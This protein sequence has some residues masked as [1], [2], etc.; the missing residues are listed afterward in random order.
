M[1]SHYKDSTFVYLLYAFHHFGGFLFIAFYLICE[2]TCCGIFCISYFCLIQD[3]VSLQNNLQVTTSY[4]SPRLSPTS[5][6]TTGNHS[7]SFRDG[8]RS[9]RLVSLFFMALYTSI[10]ATNQVSISSYLCN[11]LIEKVLSI[12]VLV[13]ALLSAAYVNIGVIV[14]SFTHKRTLGQ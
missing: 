1:I 5:P 13:L 3:S 10:T 11:V 8:V 4:L 14:I 7:T 12:L 6:Q 9:V 2:L